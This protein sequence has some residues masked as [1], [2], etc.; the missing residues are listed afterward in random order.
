MNELKVSKRMEYL[1]SLTESLH[2][3]LN[4]YKE[5]MS[6]SQWRIQAENQVIK[7]G[8]LNNGITQN[9]VP[10]TRRQG[11]ELSIFL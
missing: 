7:A 10:P 6:T 4:N 2:K 11:K 3:V 8:I 5:K 9:H 1:L